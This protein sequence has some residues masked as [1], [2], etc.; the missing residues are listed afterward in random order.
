M[1]AADVIQQPLPLPANI[2]ILGLLQLIGAW[3]EAINPIL[4]FL[5]FVA[6]I[7]W[8]GFQAW[9]AYKRKAWKKDGK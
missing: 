5:A 3:L 9:I 6:T 1:R 4:Q 8:I 2:G 7:C